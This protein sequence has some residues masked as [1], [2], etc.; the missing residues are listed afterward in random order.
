MNPP[1]DPAV[2]IG[3]VHLKMADLDRALTFWRDVIGFEITQRT[4]PGGI[5]ERSAGRCV[6]A[7]AKSECEA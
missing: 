6:S 2:R 4:G 3:H 5:A 7:I 1:L